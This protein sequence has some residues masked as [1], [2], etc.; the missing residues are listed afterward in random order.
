MKSEEKNGVMTMTSE[1]KMQKEIKEN[2]ITF[3]RLFVVF[4]IGC[5]SGVLLE[6]IFCLITK[7]H[8]ESHVVSVFGAFNILYGAG[9]MLF[10]S[11]A[12]KLKSKP[13]F[14]RVTIMTVSAT[15]LE[16]GAGLFLKD[17]LG[18]RAWNYDGKFL[19][20]KGVICLQFTFIWGFAAFAFCKLQPKISKKLERIK[21]RMWHGVCVAVSIFMI[22]NLSLTALS[23]ARWSERHY[24][25]AAVTKIQNFLDVDAPDEWMQSRFMEW[26]F[27]DNLQ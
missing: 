16:L 27:L 9:A 2:E 18:M 23:I 5:V 20:Y 24:G 12:V 10:Y 15:A 17:Y 26:E 13:I 21:G 19:N 6:G 22:L 1:V 3:D 11:G 14:L 25:V 8:W 4:F 7:G